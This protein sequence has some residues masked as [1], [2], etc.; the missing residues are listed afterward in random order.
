MSQQPHFF[1]DFSRLLEC[2]G[3][4]SSPI[5]ICGDFNL[6]MDVFEHSDTKAV[7]ETLASAGLVQLVLNQHM[8]P[9]IGLTLSSLMR[10]AIA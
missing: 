7:N 2:V 1:E 3:L 10:I 6:H 4:C 5:I 8:L 9:V